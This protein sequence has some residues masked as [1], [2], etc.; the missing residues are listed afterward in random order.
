[1]A[2]ISIFL[3][4]AAPIKLGSRLRQPLALVLSL[5]FVLSAADS[6]SSSECSVNVLHEQK[7]VKLIDGRRF[8]SELPVERLRCRVLGMDK[9]GPASD[10]VRCL[11]RSQESVFQKGAPKPFPFFGLIDSQSRQQDHRYWVSS[12]TFGKA[13][14]CFLMLHGSR[15]E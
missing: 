13:R 5:P 8:E 14:R 7:E 11:K 3:E 9:N 12:Q 6:W 2:A 10:D 4:S 1:M 15:R